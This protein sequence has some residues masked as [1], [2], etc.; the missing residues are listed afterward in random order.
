MEAP[1]RAPPAP[2]LLLLLLLATNGAGTT[3]PPLSSAVAAAASATSSS[4][5]YPHACT[6]GLSPSSLPATSPPPATFKRRAHQAHPLRYTHV[7]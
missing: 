5:K 6:S 2:L 3:A 7:S 1:A 4:T